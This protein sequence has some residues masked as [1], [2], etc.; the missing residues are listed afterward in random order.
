MFRLLLPEL[1]TRDMTPFD[2]H[3]HVFLESESDFGN[4]L[5]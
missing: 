5:I 1:D 2:K 4:G 3:G